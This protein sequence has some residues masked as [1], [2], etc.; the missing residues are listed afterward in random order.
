VP[1]GVGGVF[2]ETVG[3]KDYRDAIVAGFFD[4]KWKRDRQFP[5]RQDIPEQIIAGL[6]SRS[7]AAFEAVAQEST[8]GGSP[9]PLA[10][11]RPRHARES[12]LRLVVFPGFQ[13]ATDVQPQLA[14]SAAQGLPADPQ[15]E[16]GLMLIAARILQDAGQ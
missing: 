10:R 3:P 7:E 12:V 6:G 14:E 11:V 4:R 1:G 16:G 9:Q 2:V 5:E 8:H 15:S 13:P